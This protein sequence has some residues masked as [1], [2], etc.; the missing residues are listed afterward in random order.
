MFARRVK[1]KHLALLCRSLSTSLSAGVALLKTFETASRKALRPDLR[2]SLA[3]VTKD[4]EAGSTLTEALDAQ[5]DYYPD[6]FVDMI[7]VGEQTGSLP[8][9]L[10]SLAEHYESNLQLK[11]DFIG[12]MTWPLIQFGAAIMIVGLLIFVFGMIAEKSGGVTEEFGIKGGDLLGWGLTGTNGVLWWFGG[13]AVL[14]TGIWGGYFLFTRSLMGLKLV[15]RALMSLPVIGGCMRDFGIARFSWAFYLT[16]NAGMPIDDS[17]DASLLATANGA[18]IGEAP[19]IIDS[20]IAGEDLSDALNNTGLFPEEFINIVQVSE[21]TGTVPESLHRLSPQFQEQARR[22]LKLL[23]T[24]AGWGI[25]IGTATFI[26]YIIFSFAMM[27]IGI[28]QKLSGGAF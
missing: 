26:I 10:E 22:S 13:W 16:Q 15:H 25:W 3:L 1:L 6:L 27:Y 17:L 11:R 28:L 19:R 12:Q 4:I 8:E 20:V 9:V 23:T 2:D 5:G 7:G 21:T 24:L 14:L 18:F